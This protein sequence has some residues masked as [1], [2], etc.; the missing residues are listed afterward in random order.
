MSMGW[1]GLNGES[2]E[3]VESIEE[4]ASLRVGESEA[5]V[6]R[7]SGIL[8]RDSRRRREVDLESGGDLQRIN[9][10]VVEEVSGEG[11]AVAVEGGASG[12]PIRTSREFHKGPGESRMAGPSRGSMRAEKAARERE[13]SG[14]CMGS[15]GKRD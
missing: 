2:E 12:A 7:G 1:R 9:S 14:T 15:G 3:E 5:E 13:D 11:E 6:G 4:G 8:D 10:G